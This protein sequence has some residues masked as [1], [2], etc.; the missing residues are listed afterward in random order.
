MGISNYIKGAKRIA[1]NLSLQQII[2]IAKLF[3]AGTEAICPVVNGM[4][5]RSYR[6]FAPRSL[7]GLL[8]H[9][10]KQ[11]YNYPS[12]PASTMMHR[13]VAIVELGG[14]YKPADIYAYCAH[15]GYM[16]PHLSTVVIDNA[17]EVSSDADGEVYL[18]IEVIA[19]IAPGCKIAVIFAPNTEQGFLD[20]V[21]K[22]VDMDVD[23]IS[24]SWGAPED[25]WT[26]AS[27]KAM[28]AAFAKAT[29][30]GIGVYCAS[31]DGGSKDGE[32]FGNHVDFPASSPHVIACGGT[33]LELNPDGSRKAETAWGSG[34]LFSATGSG[35]GE[36]KVFPGRKVP[37]VCGNADPQTGYITS[38][39][40]V[41]GT[42]AVAPEKAAFQLIMNAIR[43]EHV[44]RLPARFYLADKV[45][46]D[47]FFDVTSGNN[48]G[49]KA[50]P[51]YDEVTGLG[52][53]DGAKFLEFLHDNG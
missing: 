18:D 53:P 31:G 32:S 19:G 11:A 27:L 47:V 2:D 41:G 37:D 16:P 10:V 44:G 49:Y 23:A 26:P 22:A 25:S 5:A 12:V 30:H 39:G 29:S 14:M 51:G 35:G 38:L 15:N 50:G 17:T 6:A 33:R 34:S 52:V 43:N 3:C 45:A 1:P 7:T 13:T 24:I 8:P 36:S 28:D 48:G 46:P 20:A 40:Q 9:Q 4:F 42:S 21:L